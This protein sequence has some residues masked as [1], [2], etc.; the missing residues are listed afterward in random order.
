MAI[1]DK[2]IEHRVLL[3]YQKNR[4]VNKS[5]IE[6]M[7]ML[8]EL[9]SLVKFLIKNKVTKM[10]KQQEKAFL[11][12]L[13]TSY[14][15]V[16]TYGQNSAYELS[17]YEAVFNR[18]LITDLTIGTTARANLVKSDYL[19]MYQDNNLF[20]ATFKNRMAAELDNTSSLIKNAI[21]IGLEK[22]AGFREIATSLRNSLNVPKAQ[23]D[24]AVRTNIVH[25]VNQT[26][27][28]LYDENDDIIKG[29]QFTAIMD[30]RTT[31][32]CRK[33][34]GRVFTKE[35]IKR[36][37]LKIPAHWNC[38]SFWMPVF[39]VSKMG[40]DPD[41]L[42]YKTWQQSQS[43]SKDHLISDEENGFILNKE[44]QMTLD[45]MKEMEQ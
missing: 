21:N 37:G 38:R 12:I 23:I 2:F 7:L 34:N 22:G 19:K 9:D 17:K 14:K 35:D 36:L 16:S 6:L 44:K 10:T 13:S 39:Y 29:L 40:Q 25:M 5:V 20:G 11:D 33:Y 41:Q 4:I 26:N 27:M 42:D 31:D 45:Q 32:Y 3:E 18:S 8:P 1:V 15:D 24:T 43:P 30:G 28:T